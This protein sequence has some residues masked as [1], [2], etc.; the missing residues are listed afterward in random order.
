MSALVKIIRERLNLN[1]VKMAN[2]IGI[3]PAGL[4]NYEIGRRQ[5]KLAIA[6]R[7]I[8]FAKVNGINITLEDLYPRP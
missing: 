7:I 8:D 5:P 1:Q 2:F 4:N 3:T 6:Y